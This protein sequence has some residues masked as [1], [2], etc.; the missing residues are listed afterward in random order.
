MRSAIVSFV[1]LLFVGIT[2]A[3]AQSP[4]PTGTLVVTVVDTTGAVLP[5]ATVTVIGLAPWSRK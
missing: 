4:A 1:L 3:F 5:G 2:T